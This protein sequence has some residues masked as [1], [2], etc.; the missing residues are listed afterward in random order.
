MGL[1]EIAVDWEPGLDDGPAGSRVVVVDFD[2]DKNVAA[3]D[4]ARWDPERWC[5]VD[6]QGRRIGRGNYK[7]FPFH[8]VNAWGVVMRIL[9]LYEAPTALGRPVPW[10][11][12]GNR[13]LVIP[14]AGYGEN[15][16]YDPGSKSLRFY[17]FGTPGKTVYTCLSHD[18]IAHE[19]GHAVLDGIRPYYNESGSLQTAAFHEF[20]ADLTAVIS[21]LRNNDVRHIIE[22]ATE[23]DLSKDEY[24][25]HIAQEFGHHVLGRKYLRSANNKVKME[26]AGLHRTARNELKMKELTSRVSPHYCSQILT[27]AMFDIMR[28]TVGIHMEAKRKNPRQ[29]LWYAVER[30]IRVALQALDYCPP[31]D[32]Q[33]S[34]YVH[35]VL[36]RDQITDPQD[37]DEYRSLMRQVFR[38][39]QI[40]YPEDE[41]EPS[42]TE[43]YCPNIDYLCSAPMAAYHFL[44]GNREKLYIPKRRDFMIAGLYVADKVRCAYRRLPREIVLQYVWREN[45][46]LEGSRFGL[47]AGE[48]V[49]QLCGGALVYDEMGNLLYWRRKPGTEFKTRV[50]GIKAGEREKEERKAGE[51]R[52]E[53]LFEYLANCVRRGLIGVA[54]E[55]NT[56]SLDSRIPVVARRV[57]GALRLETTP[58]LRHWQNE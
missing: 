31:V 21:S 12:E 43:F 51:S 3:E 11:F 35:A 53:L 4:M 1:D 42:Y 40:P 9:S 29:A 55:K 6:G 22:K 25:A 50:R 17:Y 44:N 38:Q 30:F 34:D 10:G 47:L 41:D 32:I 2:D 33:F 46:K 7:S 56:E 19:T 57:D 37:A 54:D 13:L 16:F 28:G 23:G 58:H 45:V 20:V 15:A 5:F 52:R 8:Q 24:A 49:S 39:R 36:R 14:H 27:G 26:D 48:N 18:I